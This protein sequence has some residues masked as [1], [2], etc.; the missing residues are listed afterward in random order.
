MIVFQY[1]VGKYDYETLHAM[2]DEYAAR[3]GVPNSEI[4]AMPDDI[5]IKNMDRNQ[6]IEIRNALTRTI[7]E[8]FYQP[9]CQFNPL[10]NGHMPC[11]THEQKCQDCAYF[12]SDDDARWF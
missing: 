4:L 3:L 8:M 11:R 2:I 1:P 12:Y 6:L 9:K 10:K 7:D 5:S